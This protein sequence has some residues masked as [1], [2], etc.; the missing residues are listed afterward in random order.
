MK[1]IRRGQ[2]LITILLALFLLGFGI[3]LWKLQSE[4]GFYYANSSRPSLG[5]VYDR[6]GDVLFDPDADASAYG[7]DHFVDVGN[8]IGDNSG[9]MT[10]T[11][12]AR[13]LA[14][15]GNFS[16][17]LGE[18]RDGSAA[19]HT[20]LDHAVNRA[21][22]DAFGG[23]NGCAVA[24]N[25][26]TGEIYVCTSRPNVNVLDGYKNVESLESGSL[27]CKVFYP[28]VPGSTQKIPTTIAALES[29]GWDTLSEKRYDC[30]GVYT[31]LTGQD[32][33]C[34]KSAGHGTQDI[35]AAFANSCNPF[36]AQLVADPDLPLP[37]I[38]ALYKR[39]GYSLDS[40]EEPQELSIDGI[41]SYTASTV[42]TDKNDF[43]TQWGCMGQG[44]TLV[45][46]MQ[47]T[48]WQS[49]VANTSGVCTMPHLID[50]LTRVNG[51]SAKQAQTAYSAQMFSEESALRMRE[52]M[53]ENGRQNYSSLLPGTDVGVKSG[54]AQ[55]GNSKT[56]NS[57]LTGFT[58][59][60]DFP[61]A[62][63]IVIEDRVEGEVTTSR[64]A[65]VML[66]DLQAALK[67]GA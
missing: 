21:V 56:E 12:V 7:Y 32:I 38:E 4:A 64:I 36:F 66:Q 35:T 63:C 28:T 60:P 43:H 14:E 19:I 5:L 67:G 55:I 34:H 48:V 22:Y 23:K 44:R 49:A 51:K 6:T 33:R 47:M 11:L 39:M 27:L 50:H 42:L 59:D 65:G 37:D 1:S 46:P 16:F 18:Q 45:S 54:T 24:Y 52:I 41:L 2:H 17:M 53:L 10:N 61:V 29:M 58:D 13:N 3:L 30:T 31:N 57:L 8:L 25:Y 15:L 20:T 26:M 9:Q 40:D 62:F